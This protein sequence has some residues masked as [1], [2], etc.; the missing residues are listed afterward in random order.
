MYGSALTPTFPIFEGHNSHRLTYH[1]VS[2]IYQVYNI[3]FLILIYEYIC[4]MIRK[5]ITNNLLITRP[6]K[7]YT[8]DP[9]TTY[10]SKIL[11]IE[12]SWYFEDHN[13]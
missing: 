3:S 11:K 9:S 5:C 2:M 7:K 10:V 8:R 13:G 1:P 4:M 6:I 12:F